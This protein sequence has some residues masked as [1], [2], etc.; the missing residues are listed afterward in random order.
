MKTIEMS[1]YSVGESCYNEIPGVCEKYN[2]KKVVLIGGKRAL[3]ATEPRIREAI[4]ETDIIITDSIVYGIECTMTNVHKLTS[5]SNVQEADVIFAIGG[6]KAIDTCKTA[7]IEMNDKMVFSFPTICSNC[8]AATAIAVVYDDNGALDHYSYP[9]CPAHIFINPDVIAKAPSEYFW[10]GIGD[11]LSK[12]CEV[13]FA[14]QG[15]ILDHT[16]TMGLALAKTC[17]APL[18]KYGKQ[19]MEDCKNDTNSAAIEAIALDIVVSTGYVSNLTNQPEYYYNSSI[20]HAFY[21]GSCSI[22]RDGH[23]LHGE[24]VSFGVLV[25]YAYAKDEENLMKM[26]KFNKSIGLP[27]TLADV[28]LDESHLEALTE[29]ATKTNVLESI[30]H[31]SAASSGVHFLAARIAISSSSAALSCCVCRIYPLFSL[32]SID[33]GPISQESRSSAI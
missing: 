32:N 28:D 31:S 15:K 33:N 22:T 10:A 1:N 3:A 14:T 30:L 2:V 27:V 5:N 8:S 11:A 7:S 6:G 21:N 24:V 26:A 13:E 23:H 16:A 17:T 4:K 18:L 25:L 9:H 12:Q 29:A 20:A 19:G